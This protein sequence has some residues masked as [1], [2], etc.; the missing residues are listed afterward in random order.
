M[1]YSV[2]KDL[3]IKY[4]SGLARP[5]EALRV[6]DW[7]RFSE[8]NE[9]YF[10]ELLRS[11]STA[12]DYQVPDVDLH[13]QALRS[14]ITTT[15]KRSASKNKMSIW[16]WLP[17][18][19]VLALVLSYG[20]WQ[21][22]NGIENKP[23][24]FAHMAGVAYFE[25]NEAAK[26]SLGPGATLEEHFSKNEAYFI[27]NGPA[28]FTFDAPYPDFKLRLPSGIWLRDI[29][30]KF[31]VEGDERY[32][33]ITVRTGIVEVWNTMEKHQVKK[34]KVLHYNSLSSSFLIEDL[35]GDF[36]Y[37]DLTL[38]QVCDSVSAYFQVHISTED[39]VLANRMLTLSGKQLPLQDVLDII[40]TTLDI[41]Y[42]ATQDQEK[43]I[44]T[45]Q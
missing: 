26:V 18:A 1:N 25:L 17:Y 27:L 19:A 33:T 41:H 5:E 10:Q 21:A 36:D 30:T 6:E 42:D 4:F 2:D 44:F 15:P 22:N 11:W 13:W 14:S 16:K 39:G 24:K 12:N 7:R 35:K 3:L 31:S 34:N 20:I 28:T 38:Q 32:A 43:I 23:L 9:S 45:T 29:G 8:S 40:S 37:K